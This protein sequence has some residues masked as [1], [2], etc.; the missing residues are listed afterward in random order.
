VSE[1]VLRRK[2]DSGL[3]WRGFEDEVLALD[4]DR[5]IY[6]RLNKSGT[7]LWERL[8]T[9]ATRSE[10]IAALTEAFAVEA[11][12]AAADVDDFVSSCRER[13]LIRDA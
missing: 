3:V 7:L 13:G 11:E 5:S 9:G 12:Q 2:E 10:L 4:T 8:E 1:P 6:L